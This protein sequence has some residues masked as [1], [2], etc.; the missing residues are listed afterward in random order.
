MDDGSEIVLL[1]G[2]RRLRPRRV[3]VGLTGCHF[4]TNGWTSRL[5]PSREA[6]H[7]VEQLAALTGR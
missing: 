7:L 1:A 5:G 4:I 3:I 6:A 2:Y